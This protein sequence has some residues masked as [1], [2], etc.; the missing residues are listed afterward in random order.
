MKAVFTIK[1]HTN[2]GQNL[3]LSGTNDVL[4]DWNPSDAVAMEYLGNDIWSATI[5]LNENSFYEYKY[6]LR[7]ANGVILWE[8]GENRL[9]YTLE[10]HIAIQDSWRAVLDENRVFL[11]KAFTDVIMKPQRR[12]HSEKKTKA[13]R[14]IR[15]KIL[16]PRVGPGYAMA[17][18]GSTIAL[19]KWQKPVIMGNKNYPYWELEINLDKVEFP[20]VYKYVIVNLSTKQII[21]WEEGDNRLLY[22]E[23]AL[24]D[25][26]L[27][28][29][30]DEDFRYASNRWKGAGVAIPVFSLRTKNSFGIGEFH[31]VKKLVD[32][33]VKTG[34]KMIQLLPINETIATH[35]W[36]DSY[37]YKSISVM[38][39]HPVY[40]NL[41]QMGKLKDKKAMKAFKDMGEKLNAQSKIAYPE[42]IEAKSHYYKLLFDQDWETI[43][44]SSDYKRFFTENKE[45]LVPYATFCYLRDLNKTSD[46]MKWGSYSVYKPKL[47]ATLTQE[48]QAHHEHIAIHYFIQYHLDKQLRDLVDYAHSKGI[49]LKGDIPIGISPQSV[50]AWT[51]P[52]LFNLNAQAGAP[53]DDFAILGQNWGFPTYNWDVMAQ[54]DYAWWRKRLRMMEKYFDAYRIDHVLGFFRIWEIPTHAS[55]AVQGYFSP[56][57]PMS[58]DEVENYGLWFDYDRFVKPYIRTHFLA[59]FFGE[60]ADFVLEKY[61]V[62]TDFDVY[63]VKEKF[64]T[65][66]KILSHFANIEAKG[67][68]SNRDI[69]VRDGLLGLLNEVL[70]IPDPYSKTPA[71]H[72]RISLHF[73]YSYRELDS[74]QKDVFNSI[75]IQYYYKRHEE[76]WK[77]HALAKLPALVNASDMLVCGEDLGMVPSTVSEVM[78]QLNIL[79][80]EIQRMPKDPSIDF[81]HPQNAPYLSVLSPSTHDLST[82]RGW[83]E[84]DRAKT[85]RF[86]R[87][88][89]GHNDE[90]PYF[91]E[92]WICRDIIKQHLYSPAMWAIFPMQDLLAMDG[93]LRWEHTDDERINIPGDSNHKWRYRM[94]Q[95]ME[96]LL[97]A[98]DFN[99]FLF[100]LVRLSDRATDY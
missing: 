100:D 81:D 5:E 41:S 10:D 1:Y 83:W 88:I 19:G 89:L 65:Q 70:F 23:I 72:P 69:V 22:P 77:Y 28:K 92:P 43:K 17:V 20:I 90:A 8:G 80:L 33:C 11:S 30:N 94:Y 2:W 82:L 49:A 76:F 3:F 16:A 35:S 61:L 9:L 96:D 91:A 95:S 44:K 47:I 12:W 14:K 51:E 59:D 75:Y 38:A 57:L 56:G 15:F 52:H 86:Y 55:H 29:V 37:P 39:L 53:P 62:E 99:E 32:W 54:D 18:S 31:D 98:D 71:Y 40:L 97:V 25:I 84:E 67:K 73:T 48:N 46:F 50:E 63:E 58:T 6:L 13:V 26:S 68:L 79:S 7:E 64:N 34:L 21:S 36:T 24:D 87:T 60:Y 4:G 85:A 45:W 93:D 42:V 27:I 74:W 78:K 66:R